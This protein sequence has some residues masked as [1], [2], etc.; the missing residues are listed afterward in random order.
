MLIFLRLRHWLAPDRRLALRIRQ[1][2]RRA[3]TATLR[4]VGALR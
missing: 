4:R 2:E 3:H 1:A